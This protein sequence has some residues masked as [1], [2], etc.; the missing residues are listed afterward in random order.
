MRVACLSA[1]LAPVP[2]GCVPCR[3]A[4]CHL[5][6]QAEITELAGCDNITIS[7]ALLAELEACTEALPRK[8]SPQSADRSDADLRGRLDA[9][10]FKELHG[11]DQMAVDKLA[12][13]A[14]GAEGKG[15]GGGGQAGR[16]CVGGVNGRCRVHATGCSEG[17]MPW[18]AATPACRA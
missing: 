10:L 6:P 18:H 17:L 14:W 1:A 5:L 12:E 16:G 15:G 3:G 9:A 13:G 8:L 4:C 11:A 2:S 7:P